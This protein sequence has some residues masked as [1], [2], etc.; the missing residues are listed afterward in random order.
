MT[1][2]DKSVV[3]VFLSSTFKDMYAERDHLATIVYPELAERLE[4]IGLEFVDIDL[5][6]GVPEGTNSWTYCRN[7]IDET[8]S[9]FIGLLGE[10]YGGFL[11]K[12]TSN[13]TKIMKGGLRLPSQKWRSGTRTWRIRE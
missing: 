9:F 13:M 2:T 12:K 1:D 8:A 5:R 3:S 11:N 6:W 4:S 7:R 10:R